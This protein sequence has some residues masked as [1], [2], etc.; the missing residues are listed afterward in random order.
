VKTLAVVIL[1][2]RVAEETIK[3]LKS[4]QLSSYK[5]TKII[6]VDNNSKDGLQEKLNEFKDIYFFANSENSGYT[7]GNNIGMK[8]ALQM[9]V[10]YVLILNPDTTIE[11]DCIE[12]LVKAVE[13]TGA[14]VVGPKI[15]FTGTKTIWYAGGIMDLA[16]V[17]GSHRGVN[18]KDTGQYDMQVETDYVTGAAMLIK[19][20]VIKKIGL[21]DDN[22]F[23][24]YEDADF[25]MRAKNKGFKIYYIPEAV[26]YH[27]NAKS[28]GLGSPLQDYFITRNRMLYGAKFLKFRTRF[29]LFREAVRNIGKA[30]RR[31]AFFDFLIGNFGKGSFKI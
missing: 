5:N 12:N 26:V 14:G 17:I 15:Y 22:F 10:D 21:F 19:I 30:T 9:G 2:Y 3:C 20:E 11:K 24:Y 27:E 1:N 7:G 28:S 8:L 16:N 4:V 25:C 18:E 6:V 23:L 31:L 13:K 29:A